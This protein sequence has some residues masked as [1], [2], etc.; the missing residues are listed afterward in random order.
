MDVGLDGAVPDLDLGNHIPQAAAADGVFQ[1][2]IG[3][4]V[5][6]LCGGWVVHIN[7]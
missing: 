2:L 7:L 3:C 5:P 6:L 1:Q 4:V